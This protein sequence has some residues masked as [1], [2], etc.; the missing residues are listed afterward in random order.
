MSRTSFDNERYFCISSKAFV[1][2]NAGGL[3]QYEMARRACC[4]KNWRLCLLQMATGTL[5]RRG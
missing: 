1:A 4:L 5:I 2:A 3:N